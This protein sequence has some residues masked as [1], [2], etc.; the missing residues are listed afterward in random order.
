MTGVRLPLDVLERLEKY[1]ARLAAQTGLDPN[2]S[3]L[4]RALLVRALDQVEAEQDLLRAPVAG[5]VLALSRKKS[6]DRI[7]QFRKALTRAMAE[8][9]PCPESDHMEVVL[10]HLD[11]G[12]ARDSLLL[13]PDEQATIRSA[14]LIAAKTSR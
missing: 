13:Q 1:R 11:R 4:I 12:G 8:L 3:D 10:T 9:G 6:A 5:Q 7:D 2:L 14:Q